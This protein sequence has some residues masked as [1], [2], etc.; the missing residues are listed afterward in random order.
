MVLLQ[1]IR[2]LHGRSQEGHQQHAGQARPG[3][4]SSVNNHILLLSI[5]QAA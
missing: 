5:G 2:Q 3:L 4:N 1:G